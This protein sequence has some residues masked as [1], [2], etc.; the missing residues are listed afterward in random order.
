MALAGKPVAVEAVVRHELERGDLRERGGAAWGAERRLETPGG[1]VQVR[2]V[3]D[4]RGCVLGV[5]ERADRSERVTGTG[6]GAVLEGDGRGCLQLEGAG[7]TRHRVA[8][9][10]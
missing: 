10:E 8:F 1:C 5:G 6:D 3:V 7:V 9:G 2:V 4:G